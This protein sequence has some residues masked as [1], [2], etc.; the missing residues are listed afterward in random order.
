MRALPIFAIYTMKIVVSVIVFESFHFE[1]RLRFENASLKNATR[2][3]SLSCNK[4]R[5]RKEMFAFLHCV[6]AALL[7]HLY[8]QLMSL[9]CFP[10][11]N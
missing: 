9:Q 8:V 6:N 7:V 3:S 1:K 5:I 10:V 4:R 11:H 2:F